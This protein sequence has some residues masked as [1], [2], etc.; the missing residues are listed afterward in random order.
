MTPDGKSE[1]FGD[2]DAAPIPVAS[3]CFGFQCGEPLHAKIA[4]PEGAIPQV[5]LMAIT[6]SSSTSVKAA[7]D[8]RHIR[9]LLTCVPGVYFTSTLAK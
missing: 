8:R 2:T 5:T 1:L 4:P 6:T 7:V 3:G 9:N